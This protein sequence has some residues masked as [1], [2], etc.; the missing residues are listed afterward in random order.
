M[1]ACQ[2]LEYQRDLADIIGQLRDFLVWLIMALELKTDSVA[3]NHWAL[4]LC[5]HRAQAFGLLQYSVMSEQLSG[6]R[7]IFIFGWLKFAECNR[8]VDLTGERCCIDWS[9]TKPHVST[10]S[11]YL[12]LCLAQMK[13]PW[14][15]KTVSQRQRNIQ[16][17]TLALI[18]VISCLQCCLCWSV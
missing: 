7:W 6:C 11:T 4:S 8:A 9:S 17:V 2:G 13:M 18:C 5:S 10:F 14:L 1:A 12:F 3:S 15:H 16:L